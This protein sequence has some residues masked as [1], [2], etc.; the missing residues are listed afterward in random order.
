MAAMAQ[1]FDLVFNGDRIL[2][3]SPSLLIKTPLH[4]SRRFPALWSL[5]FFLFFAFPGNGYEPKASC[6]RFTVAASLLIFSFLRAGPRSRGFRSSGFCRVRQSGERIV[7]ADHSDSDNKQHS[8]LIRCGE[9]KT[10]GGTQTL[11]IPEVPIPGLPPLGAREISAEGFAAFRRG[12]LNLT[13]FTCHA[14]CRGHYPTA[15]N[16]SVHHFHIGIAE[17]IRRASLESSGTRKYQPW[18]CCRWSSIGESLEFEIACEDYR[19]AIRFRRIHWRSWGPEPEAQREGIQVLNT[20]LRMVF[21]LRYLPPTQ[22][23]LRLKL[24]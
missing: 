14:G 4:T 21:G 13:A 2:S 15:Q 20:L 10:S 23:R 17:T 22:V 24:L 11:S 8:G 19:R 5:Q 3:V 12:K 9:M 1:R 18:R 7:T 16:I 6:I